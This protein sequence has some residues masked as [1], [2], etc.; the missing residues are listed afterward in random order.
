M[1]IFCSFLFFFSM[2]TFRERV[3]KTQLSKTKQPYIDMLYL[4]AERL[5][6]TVF[7]VNSEDLCI[8]KLTKAHVTDSKG[9][10]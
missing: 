5:P 2:L 3:F 6:T 4:A 10:R 9:C 8:G 7:Y 1:G